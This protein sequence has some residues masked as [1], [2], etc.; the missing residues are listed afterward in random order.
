MV[1]KDVA[2]AA[3]RGTGVP[4]LEADPALA[5][6]V[7]ADQRRV[8]A[9]R[10]VARQRRI[11]P[12]PWDVGDRDEVLRPGLL[13]LLVTDGIVAGTTDVQGRAHVELLGPG[14]VIQPW[15]EADAESVVVST[16]S[17]RAQTPLTVLLL[18]RRFALAASPWPEITAALMNRLVLRARRLS[19]QM[20]VSSL[21]RTTDRVLL[22]LWHFADL[23]GTVT[24][25]GVTLQLP[26]THSRF[27]SVVGTRRPSFTAAVSELREA[28][29]LATR[30]RSEWILRP[31]AP[32]TFREIREQ[33]GLPH[34]RAR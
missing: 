10:L 23:W 5:A 33:V 15:T 20:A 22:M 1:V 28:G 25:E 4:V 29:C 7:P 9:A 30:G 6:R 14:D 26:L 24:R 32:R 16:V 3:A 31:P 13:G 12:G 19:F 34:R 2:F 11:P 18:D 8:A 27:A 21:P 17:W